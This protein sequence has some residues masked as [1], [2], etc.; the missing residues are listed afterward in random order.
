MTRRSRIDVQADLEAAGRRPTPAVDAHFADALEQRLRAVHATGA[1]TSDA[2]TGAEAGPVAATRRPW[3]RSPIAVAA[4]AVVVI[5]VAFSANLRQPTA[6]GLE[7]ASALDTTVTLPD[8][9]FVTARPG[10][11]LQEGAVVL[12]G[13]Q[14]H[15]V[16]A[17]VRLGPQEMGVVRGARLERIERSPHRP[18]SQEQGSDGRR[19]SMD[20]PPESPRPRRSP[21]RPDDGVALPPIGQQPVRP[22]PATPRPEPSDGAPTSKPA[23]DGESSTARP[24]PSP[25]ETVSGDTSF[26]GDRPVEGHAAPDDRHALGLAAKR[27]PESVGLLWTA[28]KHPAYAFTV[29]LR[30]PWGQTPQWPLA[31]DTQIIGRGSDPERRQFEDRNPGPTRPVYRIVVV[32][33][34]GREL[35][36]SRAVTPLPP[37]RQTTTDPSPE[38]RG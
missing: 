11:V 29:V 6:P 3:L 26:D 23:P 34:E 19:V 15:A 18:P 13:P 17:G 16:V 37:E 1:N 27:A 5:S 12:T 25:A 14:G 30:A 32:D 20:P 4:A 21:V 33:R 36:R 31:G 10:L 9:S 8:G 35:G 7:F 22:R 28:F 24:S 2:R 38:S